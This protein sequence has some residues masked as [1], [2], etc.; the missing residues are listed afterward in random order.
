MMSSEVS[1]KAFLVW[2]MKVC[3]IQTFA[4]IRDQI[5]LPF[6]HQGDVAHS[7]TELHDVVFMIVVVHGFV[8]LRQPNREDAD[9]NTRNYV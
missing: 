1:W 7:D 8:V 2:S 3:V 5:L 4:A 9:M 6:Q